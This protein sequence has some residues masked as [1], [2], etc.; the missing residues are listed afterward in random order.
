MAPLTFKEWLATKTGERGR[1]GR[2]A[3]R[4]VADAGFP[5]AD[6]RDV[7]V[8]RN[9]VRHDWSGTTD[10][11]DQLVRA[12]FSEYVLDRQRQRRAER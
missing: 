8:F 3:R 5:A 12:V 9:R 4:A 10:A 6:T 7:Q 1:V 11:D 2:F